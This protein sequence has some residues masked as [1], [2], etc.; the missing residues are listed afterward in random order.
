MTRII[1]AQAC[2]LDDVYKLVCVLEGKELD[3]TAFDR[4][5]MTNLDNHDIYYY[6]AEDDSGI[7]GFASLHIQLLLHHTSKVGELQEIIVAGNKRGEGVGKALFDE[8]KKMAVQN[9]CSLL[10]VCCNKKRVESHGFYISQGMD[11]SHFKFTL[12]L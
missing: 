9:G 8:I 10:E 3:R 7:I 1:P 2:H 12:E 6:V 4:I 5:Y 11:N